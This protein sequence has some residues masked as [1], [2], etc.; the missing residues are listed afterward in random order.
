MLGL[1]LLYNCLIFFDKSL[2]K[3]FINVTLYISFLSVSIFVDYTYI[4][5]FCINDLL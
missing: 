5:F 1:F 2:H 3:Y 4:K